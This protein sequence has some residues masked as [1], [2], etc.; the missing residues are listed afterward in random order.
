MAEQVMCGPIDLDPASSP[1][2]NETVGAYRIIT[3]SEDMLTC[4]WPEAERVWMNPPYTREAGTAKPYLERLVEMYNAGIV[5]QAIVLTNASTSTN[6]WQDM[7]R[8]FAFCLV[9]HRINFV[10]GT[11]EHDGTSPRYANSFFHLPPL[12][13]GSLDYVYAFG[14][15]FGEIGAIGGMP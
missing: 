13:P 9:D 7:A 12:Q 1:L 4:D 6:W 3:A 8:R 15:I 5:D 10:D 2:A 14:R 11:G